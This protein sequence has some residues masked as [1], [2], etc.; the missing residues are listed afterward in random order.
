MPTCVGK[1]SFSIKVQTASEFIQQL[2]NDLE[3]S[4][5]C[6]GAEPV[7]EA[8]PTPAVSPLG[9]CLALWGAS[10]LGRNLLTWW[11]VCMELTGL[12]NNLAG[13]AANDMCYQICKT[14]LLEVR[15]EQS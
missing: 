1:P 12:R 4:V 3:A 10:V 7:P 11:L 6:G 8:A 9:V 2:C 15:H 14:S 13:Y 5:G